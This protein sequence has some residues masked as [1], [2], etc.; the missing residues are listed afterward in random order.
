MGWWVGSWCLACRAAAPARRKRRYCLP[1]SESGGRTAVP[2]GKQGSCCHLQGGAA[3]MSAGERGAAAAGIPHTP[4][5]Y[6]GEGQLGR[7]PQRLGCLSGMLCL[8]EVW[9]LRG[10]LPT[11][12]GGAVAGDPQ[13]VVSTSRKMGTATAT[14]SASPFQGSSNR[15]EPGAEKESGSS[16]NHL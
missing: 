12:D 9:A 8:R 11:P 5:N 7:L 3:C 1:E 13:A 2:R 4:A 16:D 14:T 15:R 6:M 10:V